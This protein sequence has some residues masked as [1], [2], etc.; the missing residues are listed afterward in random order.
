MTLMAVIVVI[1]MIFYFGY[2]IKESKNIGK[3]K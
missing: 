3:E 2:F 1:L